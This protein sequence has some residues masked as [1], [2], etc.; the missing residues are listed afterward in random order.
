[1]IFELWQQ[2]RNLV[3]NDALW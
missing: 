2:Q 1:M 3:C